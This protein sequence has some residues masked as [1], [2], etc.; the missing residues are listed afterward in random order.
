MVARQLMLAGLELGPE[1]ELT[2]PGPDSPL[3]FWEHIAFR[4]LNDEVLAE[5]GGGWD[6]PPDPSPGWELG[7]DMA[8]LRGSGEALVARFE[9]S[10]PWGWKDPRS[11]LTIPFWANLVQDLRVIACVRNPLEVAVSLRHRAMCSYALSFDLWMTYNLALLTPTEGVRQVFTH[12]DSA[13]ASPNELDRL[14]EFASLEPTVA[15]RQEAL[16]FVAPSQRRRWYTLRDMLDLDVP[17]DVIDLY[18]HLCEQAGWSPREVSEPP[19]PENRKPDP[20]WKSMSRQVGRLDQVLLRRGS[21]R[22]AIDEIAAQLSQMEGDNRVAVEGLTSQVEDFTRQMTQALRAIMMRTEE[23]EADLRDLVDDARDDNAPEPTADERAYSQ[24]VAAVRRTARDV[25][26]L[27]ANVLVVSK[28]DPR[29]LRLGGRRVSHFP[30]G[31]DGRYAGYHPSGDTAAVAHLESMRAGGLDHLVI[32][33]ASQWWMDHYKGFARHLKSR[34]RQLYSDDACTVFALTAPESPGALAT[35]ED[36]LTE[37]RAAGGRE[38]MVLDLT[39]GS[40]LADALPTRNSFSPPSPNAPLPYLSSTIDVVVARH[41]DPDRLRDAER[42]AAKILV[43]IEAA[44]LFTGPASVKWVGET[45]RARLPSVSIVVPCYNGLRLTEACVRALLE[46]VPEWLPS[47]IVFV[48]DASTDGTNELL[49]ATAA[50]DQRVTVLRNSRNRGY[51]YSVTRGSENATGEVLVFLN[52]DTVP[53]SG[54][55]TPTLALFRAYNDVG[56][57]GGRLVYPDGRLQE[58]GGV[59]FR[60][61][62]PAKVG[63]GHPNPDDPRYTYVRNIDYCS[64]AFLATPRG[65]FQDLGGFDPAYDPGYFED[66]DYCFSL[67]K[68]GYR[69]VYQPDSVIV[70]VEGGTAGLDATRGFKRHQKLNESVFRERWANALKER[71]PRPD[72]EEDIPD[73]AITSP[74]VSAEHK[75]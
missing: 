45:Q 58:A 25:L 1:E 44:D 65:L 40:D 42:V 7:A 41:D 6:R 3:G 13:F 67:R 20:A 9:G 71:P 15:A 4:E 12:Y 72:R 26:P 34:Y 56:A 8:G 50:M 19:E 17:A 35:I 70:H 75:R 22:E 63:Y 61:G 54:W 68:N 11:S 39:E 69:V 36:V 66:V 29:L 49:S 21:Q 24:A 51:L 10:E 28:G 74:P 57:V 32:P 62:T 46:T 38:P 73:V 31:P 53:L 60:D 5:L 27:D 33:A 2:P 48:D 64:G 59:I 43:V 30:Q 47:E 23:L 55:L 14:C 52:N 16:A 18:L 37:L